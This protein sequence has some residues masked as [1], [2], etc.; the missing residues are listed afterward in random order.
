MDVFTAIKTRK[1]IRRFK[2]SPFPDEI[3][4]RLLDAARHAPTAGNVQPWKFFVVRNKDM[5]SKLAEAAL[6]QAWM[7]T[8]P[9]I[10]VVCPDL[11]RAR[12]SYGRRGS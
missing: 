3:L 2:S 4:W 10:I 8:A 11:V 5:Q 9:V 6:G 1:S 7:T 12:A